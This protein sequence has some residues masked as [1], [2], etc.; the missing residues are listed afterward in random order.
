MNKMTGQG[1]PTNKLQGAIGQF[2]EN[3]NNGDIYEC[4]SILKDCDGVSCYNWVLRASGE[5]IDDHAEIFGSGGGSSYNTIFLSPIYDENGDINMEQFEAV[6]YADE[7]CTVP[8]TFAEGAKKILGGS[9]LAWIDY[10]LY[11]PTMS[12]HGFIQAFNDISQ[13]CT[14]ATLWL[15]TAGYGPCHVRIKY[16]D[17]T[18]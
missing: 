5:H 8:L 7:A 2:Y 4:Q 10:S 17:T 14:F 15:E 16:S 18:E 12:V 13:K 9:M 11:T 6:A 3:T 1:C